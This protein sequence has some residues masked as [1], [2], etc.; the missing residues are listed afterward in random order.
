MKLRCGLWFV[1]PAL[2]ARGEPAV[3]LT[4]EAPALVPPTT[5]AV[6]ATNLVSPP[7][8]SSATPLRIGHPELLVP[9]LRVE[10]AAQLPAAGR[11]TALAFDARGQLYVALRRS[12][13]VG[14]VWRLRDAD[15]DGRFETN[16]RW[17]SNLPGTG[18]MV[19]HGEGVLLA[20]GGDLLWLRGPTNE[21]AA[22]VTTTLFTGLTA[23]TRPP[24]LAW[25]PDGR[26]H[27]V[28][29]QPFAMLQ[30][31][32]GD[33]VA[34]GGND[35]SFDPRT[36]DFRPEPGGRHTAI[37]FDRA[38]RRFTSSPGALLR[39]TMAPLAAAQQNPFFTWPELTAPLLPGNVEGAANLLIYGGGLF[40][41]AYTGNVFLAQPTAG[42]VLRLAG[43]E[44]GV[45]FAP[46]FPRDQRT[47]VWLRGDPARFRPTALAAGPEGAI[48][49]ADAG[50]D[51][52]IGRLW[53]VLPAG[54]KT[55][56]APDLTREPTLVLAGLLANPNHWTRETAAR[57]LRA[58]PDTNTAA[59]LRRQL[60]YGRNAQGRLGSLHTLAAR[61]ELAPGDLVIALRDAD[62]AVREAAVELATPWVQTDRAPAPLWSALLD[63][64]RDPAV[65]VRLQL[66]LTLGHSVR[67][68]ATPA[69]SFLLRGHG[70]DPWMRRAVLGAL[71]GR[72]D[73]VFLD[74]LNDP[75]S[76]QSDAAW[77]LLLALGEMAGAQPHSSGSE[78]LAAIERARPGTADMFQL[79]GAVARGLHDGGRDW[80]SAAPDGAWRR[81][82]AAALD[83]SLSTRSATMRAA[84]TR[85]L[86]V[87]GLTASQVSDWALAL[88]APGE[89]PEVQAAAVACLS[90]FDD[91][92]ILAA[93]FQRWPRL[94]ES[95]QREIVATLLQRPD[96]T[97]FLMNA[98]ENGVVP[99]TALAPEQANFLRTHYDATTAARAR[100]LLGGEINR[101]AGVAE[102]F[103]PTVLKL[104]GDA[105]RGRAVF[106][107][108]CLACH[109][110][111][112]AG[113]AF[114]PDLAGAAE[115][116]PEELLRDIL[117]PNARLTPSHQT[118]VVVRGNG[119]LLVG[120][121]RTNPGDV[122]RVESREGVV[123]YV[124]Q[125]LVLQTVPQSWSLMPE[126]AAAGL[127]AQELADLLT[128]L[129][130][131]RP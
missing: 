50:G 100:A 81:F 16:S 51:G 49:V 98:L 31:E 110:W 112:G 96:R 7:P 86:G 8:G 71:N 120:L 57:L 66:A 79:A 64:T 131:G 38:G 59:F 74:L 28:V 54:A 27:A 78:L 92:A 80:P 105:G 4:N 99:V 58:M 87:S 25:R 18:G 121:V 12:G 72:A 5:N 84:A 36:G 82:A 61:R 1:L 90:R 117:E 17:A 19:P 42:T 55:A 111:D 102:Q 44:S 26:V 35:F 127:S 24:Q 20:A 62:P 88:L 34:L 77:A 106:E 108:R 41:E 60:G 22:T 129:R 32:S 115:Q 76:R 23:E 53:R 6:A 63:R 39:L 118:E 56:P 13:E 75:R 70:N 30:P 73:A 67:P 83:I 46:T 107:Q 91:P 123:R 15:G 104:A 11:P 128:F 119:E 65:R 97:F 126:N 93:Y 103:A 124:P 48:Y 116:P 14:E 2:L 130:R 113:R 101:R 43:R 89:S 122:L 95:T 21:A 33:V 29:P 45:L 37:A 47:G 85:Y 69:L 94:A 40:P 125:R 52:E 10:L 3:P 109:Q 9:G 68:A 114:G